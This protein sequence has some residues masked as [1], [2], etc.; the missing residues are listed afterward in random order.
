MARLARH[1]ALHGEGS[2]HLFMGNQNVNPLIGIGCIEFLYWGLVA[3]AL[4]RIR[5]NIAGY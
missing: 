4:Y 5:Q 3:A 1:G 2:L